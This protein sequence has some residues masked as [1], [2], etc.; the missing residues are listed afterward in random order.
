MYM[1]NGHDFYELEIEAVL[2]WKDTS[3]NEHESHIMLV[4]K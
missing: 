4:R 1:K 2:W 3:R